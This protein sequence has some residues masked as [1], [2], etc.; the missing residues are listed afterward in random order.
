MAEVNLDAHHIYTDGSFTGFCNI[1]K[2]R[3][4][5]RAKGMEQAGEAEVNGA[6]AAWAA[7]FLAKG[8]PQKMDSYQKPDWQGMAGELGGILRGR[9][10]TFREGK[11]IR[12]NT[13]MGA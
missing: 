1:H 13:F 10:V 11:D 7:V 2:A 12:Q 3:W 5:D 9:V 4:R 6:K 8:A